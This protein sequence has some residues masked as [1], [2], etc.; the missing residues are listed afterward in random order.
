V[1]LAPLL[2]CIWLMWP[3]LHMP[4]L[5]ACL[6]SFLPSFFIFI[7]WGC[8]LSHTPSSFCFIFFP[9]RVLAFLSQTLILLPPE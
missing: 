6:L 8:A 4:G 1:G 2:S 7:F 5:L 3:F 9:D